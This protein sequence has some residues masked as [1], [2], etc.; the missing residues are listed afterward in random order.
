MKIKKNENYSC[1]INP[2]ADWVKNY[3]LIVLFNILG[4]SILILTSDLLT[5]FV[6]VELQ[7]FSLYILATLNK[8]S[9][10]STSAGLKYF[11]IGSLASSLILLGIAIIYL[12]TGITQFESLYFIFNGSYEIGR[13]LF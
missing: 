3:Y 11:L 12:E 6:A 7:S 13:R 1:W 2:T 4:A 5:M 9:L 10:F 8:E